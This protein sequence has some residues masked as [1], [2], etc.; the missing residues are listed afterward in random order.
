MFSTN[1]AK[2]PKYFSKKGYQNASNFP[3]TSEGGKKTKNS[4]K[5]L[6][7]RIPILQVRYSCGRYKISAAKETIRQDPER[8][9]EKYDVS[10]FGTAFR[11]GDEMHDDNDTSQRGL[12]E[13]VR[14]P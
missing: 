8:V 4:L 10:K 2:N 9:S 1:F 12:K 3:Y 5:H 13:R 7:N 6:E 14:V 11:N